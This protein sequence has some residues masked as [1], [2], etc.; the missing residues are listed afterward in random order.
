MGSVV[1]NEAEAEYSMSRERYVHIRSEDPLPSWRTQKSY[2]QGASPI[3]GPRT[4]K[5]LLVARM[6]LLDDFDLGS[7]YGRR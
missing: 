3:A 5:V 4:P 1:E 2:M 6:M 7:R